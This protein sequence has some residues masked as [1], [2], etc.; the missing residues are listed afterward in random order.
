MHEVNLLRELV[1]LLGIGLV[2]AVLLARLK[3]PVIAGLLLAGAL[4]GPYG[5]GLVAS[6]DSVT[7]LAEVG[8]ILLLFTIGLELSLAK[9]ARIG[10]TAGLGGLLQVLATTAIV[11]GI[12]VAMGQS[13]QRGLV[14][15][16]MVALSSTAIVL[17]GL[18]DRGEVD[19]PH[20]R[21]I[22]GTLLLQDLC[23]VPMIML[24]PLL[25]D[26]PSASGREMAW[27]VGKAFLMVAGTVVVAR[28]LL[29]HL[30]GRV[31]RT[32]SRELF[33]LAMVVLCLGIAWLFQEAGLSLALGAFLAGVL[34]AD[35]EF[36]HR[37]LAGVLPMRDLFT[38]IFF[39]SLGMLFDGRAVLEHPG[40]VAMLFLA[41]LFGKGLVA[42]LAGMAMR[43]PARAA[44]LAGAGL[45][46][47][48]EFS[49]VLAGEA[50]RNGLLLP[51][52]AQLLLA[53][54]VLTMFVTPFS[55]RF[56]PRLAAGAALLRPLERLLGARGI[57]EPAP[58]HQ[59]LRDHVVVVGH[60]VAGRMLTEALAHAG[61][62]YLIVELNADT[63]REAREAGEPAYYGDITSQETLV[64]AH[65]QQARALVLSIN[66]P[67]AARRALDVARAAAPGTPVFVRT[68]YLADTG[69]LVGLGAADVV[70]E[71][72]EA[73]L[74]L[75]ARVL[76][77]LGAGSNQL[78]ERLKHARRAY[79]PSARKLTVPR[80]PLG[81]IPELQGLKVDTFALLEGAW[82]LG[83]TPAE[84]ELR[85]RS[86]ASVV[87]V[88]RAGRLVPGSVAE[89]A[90][91]AG[92][93]VF[94]VGSGRQLEVAAR[95]LTGGPGE[96]VGDG[97]EASGAHLVVLSDPPEVDG[98]VKLD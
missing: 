95:L 92:D 74:E 54:G 88:G 10:G 41:L 60:G 16:F 79:Q 7:T 55:L 82:A 30:L 48:S 84:I 24:V 71:E 46:Q 6:S 75:L 49:F 11:L 35:S 36:A 72:L 86:G 38:S 32:R 91:A 27:A 37:A 4:A 33:L 39:L 5:L 94:L 65:L 90:L 80:R 68:R 57:A 56:F 12:V 51:K 17:R 89:I 73:G 25:G 81:D 64:H 61:V 22:V 8:V 83:R 45:A 96:Q 40:W 21:L 76:R 66:D 18:Q 3:L 98:A 58:E 19:A 50:G 87:G 69:E 70:H 47:F 2:V 23:V 53:A 93:R 20:G 63:V 85:S 52:E 59:G 15:G 31:A 44:L 34:L 9:L 78:V 77:L 42:T 26:G 28:L 29:P 13:W 62:P 97:D 1:V 14:F 67:E 43:F